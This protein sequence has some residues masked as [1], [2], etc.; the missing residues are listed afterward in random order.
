MRSGDPYDAPTAD[1]DVVLAAGLTR[2][3]EEP[4]LGL[5]TDLGFVSQ[6]R[7]LPVRRSGEALTWLALVALP[8]SG[9]LT[10]L[11]ED[12]YH[13]L[14]RAVDALRTR[15]TRGTRANAAADDDPA[16][17][18]PFVLE[19]TATGLRIIVPRDL[20]EE[21]YQQLRALDLTTFRHDPVRYDATLRRWVSDLDEAR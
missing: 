4:L 9:F 19:D 16:P 20:P 10:A 5:L 18:R 17:L 12:G 3:Q 21:A 8:L 14:R 1:A 6:V 2:E 11:G 13:R 15:G 7:V